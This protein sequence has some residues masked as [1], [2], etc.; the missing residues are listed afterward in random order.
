MI[1]CDDIY[2][3][4]IR[5]QTLKWLLSFDAYI[6]FYIFINKWKKCLATLPI[7]WCS[8]SNSNIRLLKIYR[9]QNQWGL[10]LRLASGDLYNE[11][12]P[13]LGPFYTQRLGQFIVQEACKPHL[14]LVKRLKSAK[15]PL[16]IEVGPI[17]WYEFF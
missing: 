7:L 16:H 5:K 9:K 15:T 13:H 14:C 3:N 8:I 1:C 6:C 11:Y 12:H 10:H 2:N 4:Q 17:W